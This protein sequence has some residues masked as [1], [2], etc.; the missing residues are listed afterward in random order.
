[1]TS[2]TCRRSPTGIAGQAATGEHIEAYVSRATETDVRVYEGE[3]EHFTSA[4]TEGIGI[5]VDPRRPHRLRLRRHARRTAVAEVLA[6]ARDNVAFGT[7]DEWAGLAEPDG[8]PSSSRTCGG[9]S[10]CRMPTDGQDRPGQGA[11]A[12]D[13]RR[14]QPG[15]GRRRQ[16]RRRPGRGRRGH[17]HRHR[18]V[19][20]RDRLLRVVSTLADDGDETQTG[21]GFSV[22]RSPA[23]FDLGEGGPGGGRSGDA[24]RSAPPSRRR[25]GRRWCSTRTSRPSFLGIISST[26]N[27]ETVAK[28]R[29]LFKDRLGEN[30]AE[31]DRDAGRRSDQPAG[32]HRHRS[33]RRGAGRPAQRAD[34]GWRAAA[35]RP[36]VVHRPPG[37][38]DEHRQRHPRWVQ[39]DARRAAAWR[40]HC[41]LAPGAR[42]S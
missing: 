4:Q 9:T 29:S 26:L 37:R 16:L 10:C 28:G 7:P 22:G 30:V 41:C 1:M 17:D 19:G 21:F 2:T 18:H 13:A 11:R 24:A 34:R 25:Q 27:G 3:V 6:E 8:V 38:H 12:A 39:G 15:P 5:R 40:C 42:P 23:E 36:L 32:V 33:R 31:P 35:V 14:R 20:P